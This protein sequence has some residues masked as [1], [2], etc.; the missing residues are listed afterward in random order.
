[1]KKETFTS[2]TLS[3]AEKE[4]NDFVQQNKDKMK[5]IKRLPTYKLNDMYYVEIVFDEKKIKTYKFN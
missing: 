1:M 5:S 2:K 3:I 4:M